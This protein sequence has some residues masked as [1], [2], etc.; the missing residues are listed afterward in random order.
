MLDSEVIGTLDVRWGDPPT[1]WQIECEEG[2]SLED[3]MPALGRLELYALGRVVHGA[4]PPRRP[5]A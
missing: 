3:L 2:S 4:V 5:P 1:L